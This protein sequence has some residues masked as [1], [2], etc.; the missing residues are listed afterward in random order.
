MRK[1]S[2]VIVATAAAV[3]AGAVI[4][5]LPTSPVSA[6]APASAQALLARMTLDQRVGQLL[7]VGVPATG[8]SAKDLQ[9]IGHYHVGGVILTG[10]GTAGTA[11]TA[12]LSAQLQTQATGPGNAGVP[13]LVSADQEG[14]AV[15][16][17]KGP[18]FSTIPSALSQG[19]EATATLQAQART[20]GAQLRAAAVRVDLA[21]VADTVPAGANNPPI[22]NFD[23]Q[24]GSNPTSVATHA[25]AFAAGLEGAGVIP[26]IKHFPGLGRVTANTDTTSGVTDT[27][28]TRTDPFLAPFRYAAGIG[29]PFVMMSTAIYSRIDASRPAAFS[30][31]VVTG[32]LRGDLGFGGVVVSDDLGNARQVS[33]FTPGNRALD[34]VQAGGDLVL[35]VNIATLP[36]MFLALFDKARTDAAFAARVNQSALRILTAKQQLGLLDRASM[37]G[38]FTGDGTAEKTVFRPSTGTWFSLGQPAVTYGQ[39]GDIPLPAD[40]NGDG[41]T[42]LSVYRPSTHQWFVR[43]QSAITWGQDGDIPVPADYDGDGRV[44]RAVFRPSTDVWYVFGQAAVAFGGPGDI[45]VPGDYDGNGVADRAVFRPADGTWHVD[46]QATV[47]WGQAGDVPVPG[48]WTGDGVADRTVYR[49]GTNV[50][51]IRGGSTLHFGAAGDQLVPADYTGDGRLDAAV[52]RPSTH[53]FFVLGQS[54]VTFGVAGDQPVLDVAVLR[55]GV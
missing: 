49:P 55:R 41:R 21:P 38:D 13:L 12:S 19:T 7:M 44:D 23:R 28:T 31:T 6:A 16:V 43:G 3:V 26:T 9:Q 14:G 8:A 1:R 42:D 15:Q 5:V 35:T 47:A 39:R 25:G 33:G 22:G 2:L 4:A 54:A 30:P 52:Y 50:W 53:Q 20:W 48:D 46:G 40:Y 10:R 24:F 37:R 36:E 27:V 45:P 11:A 18:G 51:W 29:S 17:L 34:F 32:M